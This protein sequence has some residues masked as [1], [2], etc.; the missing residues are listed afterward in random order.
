MRS[1][2]QT[3]ADIEGLQSVADAVKAVEKTAASNIRRLRLAAPSQEEYV[4]EVRRLLQDFLSYR[5]LPDNPLLRTKEEG[6][7]MLI[8]IFGNRG[9]VGGLYNTLAER[10]MKLKD[11]YDRVIVVGD[12]GVR[13]F[14]EAGL[15]A[16]A[17]LPGPSDRLASQELAD[18][19]R[20][21][22]TEFESGRA[23]SVDILYPRFVSLAQQEPHVTP[24][25]PLA[26]TR[27]P[28]APPNPGLPIFAPS[29]EAV[30]DQLIR[31]YLAMFFMAVMSEAKLSIFAAR[32][33]AMEN[34]G[35]LA[36]GE[37]RKVTLKYFKERRRDL[38]QKQI[39]SF[40]AHRT[41]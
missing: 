15:A 14:R 19:S 25:L 13:V 7:A 36:E 9:L 1:Y 18:I 20:F 10:L 40:I 37:V 33:L 24:F 26:L 35:A 8:A 27:P 28:G 3:M 38:T 32:T 30:A 31:R 16:E 29:A 2:L 5:S 22:V 4:A 6:G 21:A 17:F 11:G 39:Q 41:L 23:R 34:A 12:R